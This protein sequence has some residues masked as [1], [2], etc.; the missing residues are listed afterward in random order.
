[1]KIRRSLRLIKQDLEDQEQCIILQICD[2]QDLIGT[3]EDELFSVKN[4]I[5]ALEE[6]ERFTSLKL[7]K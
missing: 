3:L 5:E 1:M 7:V 4:K 2:Y 6:I